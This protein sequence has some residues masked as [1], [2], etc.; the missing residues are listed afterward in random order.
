LG[1]FVSFPSSGLFLGSRKAIDKGELEG[2]NSEVWKDNLYE[3]P[4]LNPDFATCCQTLVSYS[5][6]Q[7]LSFFI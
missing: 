6:Y 1:E 5:I 2:W 3:K 7:D 4:N